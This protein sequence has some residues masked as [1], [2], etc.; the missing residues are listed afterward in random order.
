MYIYTCM[1]VHYSRPPR[2]LP[3]S[4]SSPPTPHAQVKREITPNIYMFL[5]MTVSRNDSSPSLDMGQVPPAY[6]LK[7]LTYIFTSLFIRMPSLHIDLGIHTN[8][9]HTDS[10]LFVTHDLHTDSIEIIHTN[11]FI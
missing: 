11:I 8:T 4:F 10:L 9:S 3:V 1:Y 7:C 2:L 6:S 5:A